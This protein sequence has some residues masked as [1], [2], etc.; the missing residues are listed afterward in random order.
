MMEI[1]IISKN[2]NEFPIFSFSEKNSKISKNHFENSFA[3]FDL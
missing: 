2:L 1:Y 3:S